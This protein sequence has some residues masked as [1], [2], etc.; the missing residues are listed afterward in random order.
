MMILSFIS[1]RLNGSLSKWWLYLYNIMHQFIYQKQFGEKELIETLQS[2]ITKSNLA[3]YQGRLDLLYVF[4]CHAIILGRN[5][6]CEAFITILWNVY[7]YFQQFVEN[8]NRKIKVRKNRDHFFLIH[9]YSASRF[10]HGSI[11]YYGIINK[12]CSV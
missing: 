6:D 3:E 11:S 7:I 5:E 4:H 12:S 10:S 2:F 9:I 1:Y 8:V